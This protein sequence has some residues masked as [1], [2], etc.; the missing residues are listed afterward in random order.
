[1]SNRGVNV[2]YKLSS[3]TRGGRWRCFK[4]YRL[5]S[6]GNAFDELISP[7]DLEVVGSS[8]SVTDDVTSSS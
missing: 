1:M 8:F 2:G 5:V 7:C 4:I 6:L 3:S